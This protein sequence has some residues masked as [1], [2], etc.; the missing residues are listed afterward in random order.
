VRK[1]T[2]GVS[3]S[4]TSGLARTTGLPAPWPLLIA[5]GIGAFFCLSVASEYLQNRVPLLKWPQVG[6]QAA[7]PFRGILSVEWIGMLLI[8]LIFSP[9]TNSRHL[10]MLLDVNIAAG[11]LLLGSKGLVRRTPLAVAT[12]CMAL[13]ISLPPGGIRVFEHADQ[14]WRHIGGPAWCMLGLFV[15][16]IRTNV[17]FQHKAAESDQPDFDPC[18][19]KN[20]ENDGLNHAGAK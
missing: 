7:A 8:T 17:R 6:Q 5:A 1:I 16:L 3:I 10:Y 14:F 11:A 15:V 13:G 9:F 19:G 4:L 12:A 20:L 2:D 18:L